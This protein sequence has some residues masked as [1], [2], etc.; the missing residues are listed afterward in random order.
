MT[1]SLSRA[2]GQ[3]LRIE[4]RPEGTTVVINGSQVSPAT[5]GSFPLAASQEANVQVRRG[6]TILFQSQV[7]AQQ[8][9][10]V[11]NLRYVE[12]PRYVPGTLDYARNKAAQHKLAMSLFGVGAIVGVGFA[13]YRLSSEG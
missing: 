2:S 10:Q 12:R 7:P 1:M 6:D 11:A 5:D 3:A 4:G 13:L 8:A 9:N